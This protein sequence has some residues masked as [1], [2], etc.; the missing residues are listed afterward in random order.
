MVNLSSY[1][2]EVTCVERLVV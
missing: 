2:K 1:N